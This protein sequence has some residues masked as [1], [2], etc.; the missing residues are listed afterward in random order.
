[1]ARRER[2]SGAAAAREGCPHA[3]T[4]MRRFEDR[5]AAGRELAVLLERFRN[6]QPVITGMPRGGVPVAAEVADALGAPLDVAVVRKVGAPRNP[7]LAIGAVA[8]GGVRLL[9]GEAA[10]ALGL[11]PGDVSVLFERAEEELSD[12]VRRY[13][14]AVES[15]RLDGRTVIL[16]DDGLATGSSA[17]AALRSLRRRGAKRLILAVPVAA[18]TSARTVGGLAD[19]LVS[20]EAPEN[21]GAVGY[22]YDRFAP[23]SDAEV[24]EA[25]THGVAPIRWGGAP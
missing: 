15:A 6:E 3:A 10:H 14:G 5:R 25:L 23:T 1:M 24:R 16:I 11:A 7:E 9:S 8:E 4:S 20:I 18:R 2:A 22:W 21:L 12:Y 19:E 13:R 17:S